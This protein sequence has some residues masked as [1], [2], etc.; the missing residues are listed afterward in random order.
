[1]C[2]CLGV[3]A[4]RGASGLPAVANRK[5]GRVERVPAG[6]HEQPLRV[7][8]PLRQDVDHAVDRVGAPHC[9][10]RPSDDLDAIDVFEDE[11]FG[12]PDHA[13]EERVVDRASIHEDEQF[14]RIQAVES[15]DRDGPL[16]RVDPRDLNAG[17][18][19]KQVRHGC[20]SGSPDV[21]LGDDVDSRW[22][23]RRALLLASGRRD[24]DVQQVLDPHA[25]QVPRRGL[26]PS[27]QTTRRG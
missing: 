3:R 8:R 13:G 12:V 4:I 20:H 2:R 5:V 1:M 26:R 22:N 23:I 16:V 6:A 10:P 18:E 11:I 14:V 19:A 17:H 9:R 21:V 27:L 25:G 15:P 24:G 7:G